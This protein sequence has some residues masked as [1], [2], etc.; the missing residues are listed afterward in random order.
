MNWNFL[1]CHPLYIVQLSSFCRMSLL[2]E[3]SC[4]HFVGF[5]NM[6]VLVVFSLFLSKLLKYTVFVL[7]SEPPVIWYCHQRTL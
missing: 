2:K 7:M 3:V 4:F 6:L 5:D 1:K